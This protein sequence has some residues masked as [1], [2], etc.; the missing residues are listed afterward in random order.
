MNLEPIPD[1]KPGE[2]VCAR[3]HQPMR[4]CFKVQAGV[5]DV[6]AVLTT[7]ELKP[8]QKTFLLCAGCAPISEQQ[9]RKLVGNMPYDFEGLV[10]KHEKEVAMLK[11]GVELARESAKRI[12][13]AAAELRNENS[14][15]RATVE[16]LRAKLKRSQS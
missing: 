9:L 5:I 3:C 6:A 12:D 1:P 10:R 4:A 15:L 2:L 13:R 14:K 11:A 7:G 8:Q 16:R